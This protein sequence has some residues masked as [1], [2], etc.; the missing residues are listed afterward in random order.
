M[1]LNYCF[2]ASIAFHDVLHSLWAVRGTGTNP[3][4]A[5]LLQQLYYM[6]EEVLEEIFLDL[7]KTYD[8]LDR[9]IFL[10]ILEE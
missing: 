10:Y 7:N 1:I 4:E 9:Y 5:K 3:L 8:T 6:S 2:T